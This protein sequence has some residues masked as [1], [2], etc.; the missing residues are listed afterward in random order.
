[1]KPVAQQEGG[2]ALPEVAALVQAALVQ[3]ASML[4]EYFSI[5]I[6]EDGALAA[7]PQLID[8]YVPDMA[9]LPAFLLHLARDVEWRQEKPCFHSLAQVDTLLPASFKQYQLGASA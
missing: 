8:G 2:Q 6:G 3:Q 5:A 9:R 7:L 1:M 4:G